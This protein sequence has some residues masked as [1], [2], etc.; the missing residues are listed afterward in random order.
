MLQKAC[1]TIFTKGLQRVGANELS[2][3]RPMV[4]GGRMSGPLLKEPDFHS[5]SSEL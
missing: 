4:C 1:G 3:I 5:S 2:K